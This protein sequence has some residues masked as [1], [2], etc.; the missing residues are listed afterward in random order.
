MKTVLIVEDHADLREVVAE[1]IRYHGYEVAEAGS[2]EEALQ[3]LDEMPNKPSLIL[4][5]GMLP[6]M[7][8]GEFLERL[9]QGKLLDS[10]PVVM[11]SAAP[12]AHGS[13]GARLVLRKPIDPRYL[14]QVVRNFCGAP[15]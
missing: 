8:G 10:L 6:G 14:I 4:L 5:D 9:D 11:F 1:E 2:A 15:F 12:S 7:S 3:L 13:R